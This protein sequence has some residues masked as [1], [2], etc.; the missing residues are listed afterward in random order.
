M[1]STSRLLAT[2]GLS[3][4]LCSCMPT[5]LMAQS[6]LPE[7]T[8]KQPTAPKPKPKVRANKPKP[9]AATERPPASPRS[10]VRSARS[11]PPSTTPHVRTVTAANGRGAAGAL[12]TAGGGAGT[13]VGSGVGTGAGTGTGAGVGNGSGV[14]VGDGAGG[15]NS[16]IGPSAPVQSRFDAA[17]QRLETKVGTNQFDIGRRGIQ[18]LPQGDNTPIE[19]VLLQAPGVAQDSAASGDFHVRNE[20]ANVQYRIN[21]IRLPEGVS[22]FGQLLETSFVGRLT[23]VDGAL[24]AEFGLRTAALID[25][26]SRTDA[27]DSGGR[28]SLYGGSFGTITPVFEDGGH[29]GAWDY[30]FTGRYFKSDLGIENPAPTHDPIHDLTRQGRYF[31]FAGTQLDPDTRLS[32]ISGATYQTYQVPNNP[33]QLPAFAAYGVGSFD[34]TK[35]NENQV[36][37]SVYNVVAAQRSVGQ[38][39]AQLAYYNRFSDLR[40]QSDQIGDLV[41]NGVASGVYRQSFVNGLQGDASYAFNNAHTLRFGFIGEVERSRASSASTLL[42]T[43]GNGDPIDAPFEAFDGSSLIGGLAGVYA[44]DEWKITHQ[45][46]L[47]TGLRFDQQVQYTDANQL[48]PRINLQYAPFE[49]TV[50]HAGYARNFTPPEQSL[51][52]P[53][54][55]LK[56]A[57]TTQQPGEP[58]DSAVKPERANVFDVGVTH[59]ILPHLSAGLDAYYK[60]ARDLLDDGQFG[61]AYVLTAFNYSQAFNRGIESKINYDDGNLRAYGNVAVGEQK[62]KQVI[63]NQFLFDPDE[64]DY[65][66]DH[67][68]KTDHSQNVTASAGASYLFYGTRYNVDAIYGSGLRS[69]FANTG[70]VPGY[71]QVNAGLTRDFAG[72][73]GKPLTFR[74][75]VVNLLDRSYEIRDGSGIG[76]FAPQY[77]ERRGFFAGLAQRF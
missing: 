42:P 3:A 43:D 76:V 23:L 71:V 60:S 30:F 26:Q 45:L 4:L 13:G 19:R 62:A 12:G 22:G 32:V 37:R 44:Q 29:V 47:N 58:L 65:I 49:T 63:S 72:I 34:S 75:D 36:E 64:F 61:A 31:L 48:S 15:S 40:F 24:P 46:T 38:W 2:T 41:F 11:A 52:A 1:I 66:S 5:M 10:P 50:F 6:E 77:G 39:D 68:V 18:E 51:A 28:A 70:H 55:L 9:F 35:L 69:G 20:H 16:N 54:D 14:G 17:E 73:N 56:V 25:I 74:F 27:F 7:V 57:N 53:T 21:G 67:F 8:I 33:G 59:Q